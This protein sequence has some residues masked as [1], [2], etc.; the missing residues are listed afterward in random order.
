MFQVNLINK[1]IK[2]KIC[3]INLSYFFQNIFKN[4]NF[5]IKKIF[6]RRIRR[7][8]KLNKDKIEREEGEKKIKHF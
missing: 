1:N 5:Y 8:P 4:R 2:D 6:I 7:E 3:H